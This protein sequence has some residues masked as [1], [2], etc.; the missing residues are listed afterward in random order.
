MKAERTT[1]TPPPSTPAPPTPSRS[2][3]QSTTKSDGESGDRANEGK[4]KTPCKFF[5]RTLKGC[6]RAGR[7]PFM[8]SRDGIDKVGRC[9]ARGGKNHSAKDCPNKKTPQAVDTSTTTTPQA[10]ANAQTSLL[11][12]MQPRTRMCALMRTLRWSRYLRAHLPLQVDLWEIKWIS[13]K[14]LRMLENAEGDVGYV[15]E[16]YEGEHR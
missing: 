9:L 10:K 8:H 5:G 16:G 11:P 12:P 14:F 13:R 3:S 4:S 6:A 7:R 2:S 15:I 1:P